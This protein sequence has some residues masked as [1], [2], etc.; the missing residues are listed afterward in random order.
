MIQHSTR[1]HT[2]SSYSCIQ[3]Y[4]SIFVLMNYQTSSSDKARVAH[5]PL[6]LAKRIIACG[7]RK[8]YR[9]DSGSNSSGN[10]AE[11]THSGTLGKRLLYSGNIEMG[12]GSVRC[13]FTR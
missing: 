10:C 11:G 1:M 5:Q 7:L 8:I 9:R 12:R 4:V 13:S 2:E 6:V 3:I